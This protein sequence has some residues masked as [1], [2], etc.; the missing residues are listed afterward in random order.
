MNKV[1]SRNARPARGEVITTNSPYRVHGA[2]WAG[3][4]DDVK[5]EVGADGGKSWSEAKWTSAAVHY[6]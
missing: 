3:E 6:A 4:S 2:A 5:T 1:K